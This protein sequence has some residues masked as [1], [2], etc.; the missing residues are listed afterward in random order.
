MLER[1]GD[2]ALNAKK[3][4]E[5]LATYTAALSLSPLTPT[6]TV[7]MKWASTFLV[8]GSAEEALNAAKKVCFSRWLGYG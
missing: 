1:V 5:A 6:N 3:L 8:D 4:H 7:L 2:E